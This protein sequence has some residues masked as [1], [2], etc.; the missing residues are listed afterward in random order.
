MRAKETTGGR[1]ELAT[2]VIVTET[3]RICITPSLCIAFGLAVCDRMLILTS[4][5]LR[6]GIHVVYT[7]RFAAFSF[8]VPAANVARKHE[9]VCGALDRLCKH[10]CL[11][12]HTRMQ[13]SVCACSPSYPTYCSFWGLITIFVKDDVPVDGLAPSISAQ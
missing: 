3:L 12:E 7:S 11:N 9:V 6:T 13:F 4:R 1:T 5:L 8:G 10:M 2:Y